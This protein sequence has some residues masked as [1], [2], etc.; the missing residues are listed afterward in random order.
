ME[1]NE[2]RGRCRNLAQAT[3][4]QAVEFNP[5]FQPARDLLNQIVK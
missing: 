3:L 5:S 4:R 2:D 1:R